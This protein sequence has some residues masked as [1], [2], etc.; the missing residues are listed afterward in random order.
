MSVDGTRDLRSFVQYRVSLDGTRDLAGEPLNKRVTQ[1][2]HN[3]SI[4]YQYLLVNIMCGKV[5]SVR[6]RL[7]KPTGDPLNESDP[8]NKR[9]TSR[10]RG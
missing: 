3:P 7:S 6:V 5:T 10:L 2:G 1:E 9:V 4:F 8:L